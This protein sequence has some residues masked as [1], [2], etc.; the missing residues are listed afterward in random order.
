MDN[1]FTLLVFDIFIRAVCVICVIY[2]V[3]LM[4]HHMKERRNRCD[5]CECDCDKCDGCECDCDKGGES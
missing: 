3:L 2:S 1:T 5:G 4:R